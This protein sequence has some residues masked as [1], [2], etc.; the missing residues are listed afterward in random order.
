MLLDAPLKLELPN[1]D[2]AL[3]PSSLAAPKIDNGA[4]F[5]VSP[6]DVAVVKA[7]VPDCGEKLNVD[8]GAEE[9]PV[10]KENLGFSGSDAAVFGAPSEV[11]AGFD[12]AA[13]LLPDPNIGVDEG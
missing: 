10:P 5:F 9:A 3:L 8:L 1:T 6:P 12:A 4:S 11:S 13:V 7:D 2:A